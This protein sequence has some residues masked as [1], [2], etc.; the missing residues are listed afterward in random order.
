MTTGLLQ[1]DKQGLNYWPGFIDAIASILIIFLLISFLDTVLSRRNIELIVIEKNQRVF[2]EHFKGFFEQEIKDSTII[3]RP[4]LD[5]LQITFG[6][7]ILFGEGE[8][9]L[10]DLGQ[11]V[12]AKCAEV[13][14]TVPVTGITQIQVEGHTDTT[15]FDQGGYPRNN[16][17]LST[18]RAI[19]VVQF[20]ID[21]NLD[22]TIFSA[23]GYESNIP[24]E[25]Q[26]LGR[27]PDLDRRIEIKI[28][29]SA[30]DGTTTP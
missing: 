3:V 12:L 15:A 25:H 30:E 13:F 11:V 19:S 24:A 18:A 6:G 1:S 17:E 22:P 2:M 5:H 29:F 7:E 21:E 8:D 16:W 27:N 26:G 28:Y 20:F 10:E 4:R 14:L 23:N 9:V